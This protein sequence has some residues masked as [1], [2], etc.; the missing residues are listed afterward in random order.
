MLIFMVVL[1]HKAQECWNTEFMEKILQT[2]LIQKEPEPLSET[3][4]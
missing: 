2:G 4:I 1:R 3:L